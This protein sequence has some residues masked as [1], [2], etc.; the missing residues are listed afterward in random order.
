[1]VLQFPGKV[2]EILDYPRPGRVGVS[3]YVYW[4]DWCKVIYWVYIARPLLGLF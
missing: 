1:M 2:E 3:I 4:V